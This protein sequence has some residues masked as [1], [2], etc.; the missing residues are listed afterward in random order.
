MRM[1]RVLGSL[2]VIGFHM[3]LCF[4]YPVLGFPISLSLSLSLSLIRDFIHIYIYDVNE[5]V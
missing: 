4:V 5:N 3:W 1:L 2:I